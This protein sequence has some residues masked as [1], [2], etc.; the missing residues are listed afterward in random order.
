MAEHV[1]HWWLGPILASPLRKLV[2]NPKVI[3]GP[4]IREGMTV[5]EP[6]C[7]M[8]F[9]TLEAAQ[10]VGP[11]GKVVAADLQPKM[12]EGLK[13]RLLKAGLSERVDARLTQANRLG[14]SDLNATVDLALAI[15]MVHEVPD[16]PGFFSEVAATLKP[17]ASLLV[18]E[19]KN[20]VSEKAFDASLAVAASMGCAV[21]SRPSI[22]RSYAAVLRRV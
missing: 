21:E 11:R 20:H 14:V 7:G 18:V 12:L 16:Q 4:H 6:G 2:Q 15:Y 19:P 13:K 1:C 5:L 22:R 9:F 8:G 10:M 17:G 3:L